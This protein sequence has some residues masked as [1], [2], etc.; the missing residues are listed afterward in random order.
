MTGAE[1]KSQDDSR[2]RAFPH[3]RMTEVPRK[4]LGGG[5]SNVSDH[6]EISFIPQTDHYLGIY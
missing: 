5:V 6:I 3:Q 1:G 2:T 4:G